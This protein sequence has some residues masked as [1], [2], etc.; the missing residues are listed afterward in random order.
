LEQVASV[1][2]VAA[3][4]IVLSLSQRFGAESAVSAG[5]FRI[6]FLL[7]GITAVV[8][9]LSFRRLHAHAGIEVSGHGARPS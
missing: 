3:G 1:L 8:A 4:A 7:A 2:G 5:D 6:A 9:G